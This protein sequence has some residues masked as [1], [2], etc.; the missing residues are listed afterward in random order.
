M[1]GRY[2]FS[3]KDYRINIVC[4][5]CIFWVL[6][7]VITVF[8]HLSMVTLFLN[9]QYVLGTMNGRSVPLRLEFSPEKRYINATVIDAKSVVRWVAN[10]V[11]QSFMLIIRNQ[12]QKGDLIDTV[13]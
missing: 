7:A 8:L 12:F 5:Y 3:N 10:V 1:E 11:T 2:L 13:I 6:R 4:L 9:R